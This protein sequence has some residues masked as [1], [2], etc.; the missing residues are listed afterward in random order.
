[1]KKGFTLVELLIVIVIIG[2]LVT[3]AIPGYV[4]LITRAKNASLKSNMHTLHVCVEEF[5]VLSQGLYPGGI[6]TKVS[7]VN[8]CISPPDGDRSI[9]AGKRIP[10]FPSEALLKPHLGFENP[11]DISQK[12]INNLF[13]GPP[14]VSPSGCVYYTGYKADGIPTNEGEAAEKYKICAYGKNAPLPIILP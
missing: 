10:P 8:P 3:I 11:Y 5:A 12:A 13:S 4:S 1:M 7:E 14:A 9:A 6:D 2:I